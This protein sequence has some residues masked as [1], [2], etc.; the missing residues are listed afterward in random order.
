MASPSILSSHTYPT[1]SDPSSSDAAG[2]PANRR[3][4]RS[5]HPRSSSSPNTLSRLIIGTACSTG[6]NT[7]EMGAPPT[8][9]VGE[10][11]VMSSGNSSSSAFS[12]RNSS[13]NSASLTTGSS[14]SW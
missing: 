10:S 14:S 8:F 6:A 1:W 13:S 3:C 7:V 2:A 11:G 4:R 12:S 9:C 5:T